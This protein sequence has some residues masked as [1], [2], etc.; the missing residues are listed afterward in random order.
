MDDDESNLS[1]AQILANQIQAISQ[2][3]QNLAQRMAAQEGVSRDLQLYLYVRSLIEALSMI[4]AIDKINNSTMLQGIKLGYEI[5]DSCSHTLKAVEST[6]RFIPESATTNNSTECNYKQHIPHVK[7]VVGE[8]YSETSIAISRIL[9]IYLIPQISPASS[10][11]LLSDKIR[12]PSFLRTVPSDTHQTR[13]IVELIKTFQ[14]NW[15]GI[16][17]SDDDYGR[18]ALDLLNSLFK[19]EGICTAF[20]KTV[21]SYVG[22]PTLQESLRSVI[23]EL[24]RSSTNVLVVIAK[25]PVVSKLLKECIKVNISKIWI[26]SD[27]WSNS[28]EVR[29][30]K[31]IEKVGTVLGLNFKMGHVEGFE[32]YLKNLQPQIYNATN[33]GLEEYMQL[34]FNCTEEYREYLQCINSSSYGNCFL[35]DSL[36]LKSPLACQKNL[37]FENDNYLL[38]NIEWSKTYSTHLAII[39]IAH[40]IKDILCI[41][42]NCENNLDFS[43]SQVLE[44]LKDGH[45]SYNG[46]TFHF[47]KNGDVLIGYDLITWQLIKNTTEVKIVGSYDISGG[48]IALNRSL[49]LWNTANNQ[50]PFSNCSKSCI[51]GYYR[52]Y[53]LISCC[54]E[55]VACTEDYYSPEADMTGCLKCSQSQWSNIGS[56]RCENRITE[57][58]EF[59]DPF[60][61]TL[62]TFAATGIVVVLIIGIMFVKN[63]DAP[64]VKAAGGNYTYLLIA[65]LLISL[66]SIWFFIGEP[67]DTICKIRQPLYGISFTISISCVLIKSIRILLAFESASR[68]QKLGALTFKPVVII[69]VITGIQSCTCMLWLILKGPSLI[70]I[71]TIPQVINLQCDEGSYVAFGIMLG[72]IGLLALICFLLAYKG[73]KLPEKYNEARCITFSMLVYMFVWILFIP[74]YTNTTSDMYLSAVQAVAILASIYG[75]I[76]CHLLP[77]CWIIVFKRE[78]C[79]REIYLQSVCK[80]FQRKVPSIYR[81]NSDVVIPS[82]I[83]KAN[84]EAVQPSRMSLSRSLVIRKRHRS[85]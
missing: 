4:Y 37:S 11:S 41:N 75:I 18:S 22:H 25:D 9:S 81:G 19:T 29:N 54:Y 7:A 16:I 50:V 34:R 85:C 28:K 39:A 8:I 24:N 72:Y 66:V 47:D 15:V 5:Y 58:F 10:V 12:F 48:K 84:S 36:N 70:K 20:S 42:G 30:I 71:Y 65:S 35:N 1:P 59:K 82:T 6:L 77:V 45:F 53:S 69:I 2:V 79:N 74:I 31:N 57:Y 27:S 49:L 51:P 43:P 38:E 78:T 14:W 40:A 64:V 83:L 67:S 33:H 68:G 62:M 3:V 26:G 63:V 60:A 56:S 61:I 17:A 55:C 32:D 21:P 46:E 23:N 76:S 52:K 13:A 44:K 73:R 80:F